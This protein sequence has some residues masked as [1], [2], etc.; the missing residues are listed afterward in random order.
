MLSSI[1]QFL[2][3]INY[4][5]LAIIIIAFIARLIIAIKYGD[6]W[7]DEMFSFTYSQRPWSESFKFWLWET[8]PPL[9]MIMLKFWFYIFPAKEFFARLPSVIAGTASVY[10]IYLLAKEIFNKKIALLSS[11]CLALQ[12]YN[13]FWSATARIYSTLMLLSILSTLYFYKIFIKKVSNDSTSH[14]YFTFIN[15]LL[16]FSHL[17]SLFL[18]AGQFLTLIIT[19]GKKDAWHWIK[20]NIIPFILGSIWIGTSFYIKLNNELSNSWFI[21]L[22]HNIFS[23]L[24]TLSFIIAGMFSNISAIALVCVIGIMISYSIYK[25]SK[26]N[27]RELKTLTLL[28]IIPII[29]PFLLGVWNVKFIIEVLPLFSIIL[30]YSLILIFEYQLVVAVMIISISFF[31]Y[32]NLLKVLPQTNWQETI[33]LINTNSNLYNS[34]LIYNSFVLKPEV[35]HYHLPQKLMR[36]IIPLTLYENISWDDMIIKKNYVYKKLTEAEKDIWY[37]KN[38]LDKYDN[39]TLLQGEDDHLNELN[40]LLIRHNFRLIKEPIRAPILNKFNLYFYEKNKGTIVK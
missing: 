33:N 5:L 26:N 30:P 13:I 31:S 36:P 23:A 8:N 35:D 37:Q 11:L 27:K 40:N 25:E 14:K 20:I 6:F 16:I 24:K 15:F 7:F 3:E 22:D 21:N 34:V 1:K 39:I 32:F 29:I 2:K 10:A 19:N 17:S 18:L 4:S 12:T 9:H 28:T 38:L